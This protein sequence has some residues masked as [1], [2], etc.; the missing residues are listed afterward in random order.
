M[1]FPILYK[2]L[3]RSISVIKDGSFV[4]FIDSMQLNINFVGNLL[5]V[6]YQG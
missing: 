4:L 6:A 2:K 3:I 1:T 5:I